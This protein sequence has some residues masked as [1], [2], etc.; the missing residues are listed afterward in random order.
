MNQKIDTSAYEAIE[1]M[2][3]EGAESKD[4]ASFFGVKT[5][6][7]NRILLKKRNEGRKRVRINRPSDDELYQSYII[8]DLKQQDIADRYNVSLA[9]AKRWLRQAELTKFKDEKGFKIA[10]N[11]KETPSDDELYTKYILEDQS[12]VEL[13]AYYDVSKS[14]LQR[15]LQDAELSK[16]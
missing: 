13:M 15:W 3:R 5:Q 12:Q 2:K 4:I 7:I 16:R 14:T 10:H 9:T 6:T 8:D 1:E 11:K